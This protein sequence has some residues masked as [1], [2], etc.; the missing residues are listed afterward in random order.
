M[1]ETKWT[2]GPWAVGRS[3]DNTPLVMVPV[4]VS[5]GSGFGI[6]HINRLPRMGSARGD[7]DANA[8]LIATAPEL[9]DALEWALD[10]LDMTDT[11]LSE[12]LPDA[13][14][15]LDLDADRNAK[16]KARAALSKARGQT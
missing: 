14:T 2:P 4:H 9:Y 13:W 10:I 16:A 8:H 12:N 5:E 7:M 1:S 11:F 6:A 15:G 3:A